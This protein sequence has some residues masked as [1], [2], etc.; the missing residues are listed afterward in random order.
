MPL[1][2]TSASG[3]SGNGFGALL[4]FELAG[5]LRGTFNDDDRI[6]D[7][8]GKAGK[9]YRINKAREVPPDGNSNKRVA[10]VFAANAQLLALWRK[11]QGR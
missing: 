8:R 2:V 4:A 7:P 10:E 1:L 9:V 6:A 5:R 3:A 11:Q